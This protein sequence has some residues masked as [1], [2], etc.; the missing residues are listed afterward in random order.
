MDTLAMVKVAV[1]FSEETCW[2]S[3]KR[4]AD[5]FDVDVRKINEHQ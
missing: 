2:L 3:Q 5:L 1:L 4:M